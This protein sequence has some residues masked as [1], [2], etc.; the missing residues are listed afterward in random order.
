MNELIEFFQENYYT[1]LGVIVLGLIGINIG[2]K[3][4]KKVL[5]L[6]FSHYLFLSVIQSLFNCLLFFKWNRSQLLIIYEVN[7][8]IILVFIICEV[9][10]FGSLFLHVLK[11]KILKKCINIF[12][13]LFPILIVSLII[14]VPISHKLFTA[15]YLAEAIF[16][17]VPC[18][19]YFIEMIREPVSLSPSSN[20]SFWVITGISFLLIVTLPYILIQDYIAEVNTRL[21]DKLQTLIYF[22]YCLF[23]AFIIK[24]YICES[25]NANSKSVGN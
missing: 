3:Q 14:L 16:L 18:S 10:I 1:S 20:S 23:F 24:A 21:F 9:L 25:D 2:V 13:F 5:L 17:I 11:N 8:Y 7:N 4:R 19:W 22:A 12:Q 15:V 6:K